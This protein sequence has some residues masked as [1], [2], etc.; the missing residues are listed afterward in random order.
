MS[1]ATR[2]L[3]GGRYGRYRV[4]IRVDPFNNNSLSSELIGQ[5]QLA[6]RSAAAVARQATPPTHSTVRRPAPLLK[7]RQSAPCIPID[8]PDTPGPLQA[9]GEHFPLNSSILHNIVFRLFAENAVFT[10][11]PRRLF[12]ATPGSDLDAIMG[13]G[14]STPYHCLAVRDRIWILSPCG[15]SQV[16]ESNRQGIQ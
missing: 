3:P 15:G 10:S 12:G 6:C 2:K 16:I 1:H 14:H 8:S 5:R 4:Q 11:Y 7:A 13:P 9:P